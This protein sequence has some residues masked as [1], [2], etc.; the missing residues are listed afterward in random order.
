M[1][2]L[3]LISLQFSLLLLV[4]DRAGTNKKSV[5]SSSGSLSGSF[6]AL[7]VLALGAPAPS[8]DSRRWGVWVAFVIALAVIA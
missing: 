3:A 4:P 6:P 5:S 7:A 1:S 8:V 2:S